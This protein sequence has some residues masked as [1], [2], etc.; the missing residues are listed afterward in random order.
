MSVNVLLE[1]Q[2][3]RWYPLKDHPVQLKLISAVANGIRFPLVPAGRRSGKTERFKRF[4]VK[5]AFKI[6]GM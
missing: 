2:R 1:R 3:A 5:Q 6:P 4:L